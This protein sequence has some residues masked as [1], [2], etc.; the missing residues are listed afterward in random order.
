[1]PPPGGRLPNL[2]YSVRAKGGYSSLRK[3]TSPTCATRCPPTSPRPLLLERFTT[4]WFGAQQEINY[5]FTPVARCDDVH[6]QYIVNTAQNGVATSA[7]T[8]FG[9]NGRA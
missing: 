6:C 1:M 5:K 7:Q 8:L 9:D 4:R 3:I 2:G